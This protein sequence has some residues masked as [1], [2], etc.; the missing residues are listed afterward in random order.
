MSIFVIGDI[1]G[2]FTGL[3]RLLTHIAFDPKQDQLVFVGDLVNRGLGSLETLRFIKALGP[4][5]QTVL[6]NHDLHLLAVDAGVRSPHCNDT[7]DA[8]LAAPDK[9]DLLDWLRQQPLI[10]DVAGFTVVHAGL[11]PEWTHLQAHTL[12]R[13]VEAKLQSPQYRDFLHEMYGN[14]PRKWHDALQGHDRLRVIVN[15][16]TRLRFIDPDGSPNLKFAGEL[17][18]APAGLTPWFAV[19]DRAHQNTKLVIGHWSALGLYAGHGIHAIDTGCVWGGALTALR[20]PDCRVFQVDCSDL[21]DARP[22]IKN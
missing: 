15:A 10:L 18:N 13:E 9:T 5:A 2:C 8:I 21:A 3:T 14:H 4:A 12:A 7:L 16:M 22:L 20:L 1:Q 19:P 17:A 11:L 6:G